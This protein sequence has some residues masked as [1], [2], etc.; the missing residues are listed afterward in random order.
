M[1]E[2]K[3]RHRFSSSAK[4]FAERGRSAA[5]HTSRTHRH[6]I[7]QSF[8]PQ[9]NVWCDFCCPCAFLSHVCS[10]FHGCRSQQVIHMVV[11]AMQHSRSKSHAPE[12]SY[13]CHQRFPAHF[14]GHNVFASSDR[15]IPKY[16]GHSTG[17]RCFCREFKAP[18]NRAPLN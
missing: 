12:N 6:A 15:R 10:P 3:G 16:S 11:L 1:H 9:V 14:P 7:R 5:P 8:G 17:S 18:K 2:N 13:T 4:V